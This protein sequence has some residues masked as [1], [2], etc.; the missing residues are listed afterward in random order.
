MAGKPK[1]KIY[2]S[3][4]GKPQDM[5]ERLLS[6]PNGIY[7]CDECIELCH[8]IIQEEHKADQLKAADE[9]I[10]LLKPLEIKKK[11]DEYVVGQEAAKKALSVAVYNHYKRKKQLLPHH[12]LPA[13]L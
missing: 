5:V 9:G 13:Y 11:L 3:F 7:I 2:C 8:E 6:G 1:S 4:C 12:I 10:N